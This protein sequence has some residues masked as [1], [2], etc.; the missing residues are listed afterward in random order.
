VTLESFC[1]HPEVLLDFHPKEQSTIH[2]PCRKDLPVA[3]KSSAKN[4]HTIWNLDFLTLFQQVLA[5]DLGAI[6]S[7][8]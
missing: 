1:Q 4:A 5:C 3:A 8:R 2:A 7:A 6:E